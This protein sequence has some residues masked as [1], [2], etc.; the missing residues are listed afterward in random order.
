M[1]IY[2]T[3]KQVLEEVVQE[4]VVDLLKKELPSILRKAKRKRLAHY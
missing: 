1:N 4:A 3:S 2:I